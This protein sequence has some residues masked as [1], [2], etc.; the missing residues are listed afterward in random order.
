ME[1]FRVI[2]LGYIAFCISF[3][4]VITL[5]RLKQLK[6]RGDWMGVI[7][8]ISFATISF[9]GGLTF[10]TLTNSFTPFIVGIILSTILSIGVLR[11]LFTKDKN[12]KDF[13]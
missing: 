8:S 10:V 5:Y 12:D 2:F 3:F 9:C 6:K 1:T 13:I 11:D 7:Y 4:P